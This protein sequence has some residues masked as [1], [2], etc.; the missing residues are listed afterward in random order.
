MNEQELIRKLRIFM[1][2]Q[3][4][5]VFEQTG[6]LN[7]IYLEGFEYNAVTGK[8]STNRDKFDEWND[9]R[10]VVDFNSGKVLH[11]AVATTEPGRKATFEKKSLIL[12]GVARIAFGQYQAWQMGWHK[13]TQYGKQHPALVQC[14][15]IPVHRD[16]NQDGKRTG[17]PV[18]IG[19]GINQH[20][21]HE[22][23]NSKSIGGYSYGCLVGKKWQEHLTFLELL[24]TDIR[25]TK[26]EK[27]KFFTTIIAGD[28]FAGSK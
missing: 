3:A 6:E 26:D 18:G 2:S 9:L 21:T 27:Y 15:D 25:Y 14:S 5:K 11:N 20:S 7:I 22:R 24:K 1:L 12:G 8:F 19:R 16:V 13:F 23:F 17:D 4:Y 10:L 28:I